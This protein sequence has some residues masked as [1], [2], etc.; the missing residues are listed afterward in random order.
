MIKR[1]SQCAMSNIML[2]IEHFV[3]KFGADVK[4]LAC[5]PSVVPQKSIQQVHETLYSLTPWLWLH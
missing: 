1:R 4:E 5:C 2:S 3:G